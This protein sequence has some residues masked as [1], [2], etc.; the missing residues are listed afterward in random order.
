MAALVVDHD[1][2]GDAVVVRVEGDVDSLS[3]G[4]LVSN[5]ETALAQAATHPAQLTI[6]DL[7]GVTFFGSAG[8]NAVLDYHHKARD[9][10]LAVRFVADH[11]EVVRPIE[12]TKLDQVLEL[13]RTLEEAVQRRDGPVS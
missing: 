1:A 10:G 12:V 9:A 13:Y 8:L 11:P 7:Q 3:V 6:V 5:L 4:A 2:G